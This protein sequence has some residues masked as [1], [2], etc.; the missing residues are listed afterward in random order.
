M[1]NRLNF[2]VT[3]LHDQDVICFLS[4][5]LLAQVDDSELSKFALVWSFPPDLYY[6]NFIGVLLPYPHVTELNHLSKQ[7]PN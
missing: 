6:A 4:D 3:I 7:K 5:E 1:R 2:K